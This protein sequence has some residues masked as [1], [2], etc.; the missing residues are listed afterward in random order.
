MSYKWKP[1]KTQRREFAIKMQDIEEREAYEQRKQD[2]A[3][4]KRAGSK[5]NYQTAGGN[6]VPTK[7][8]FDFCLTEIRN[9]NLNKDQEMAANQVLFGYNNN[10]KIHHDYIHIINELRRNNN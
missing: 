9:L 10:E 2:R 1:S 4:K 7:Q 3:A 8:Q 5:H 6:Y